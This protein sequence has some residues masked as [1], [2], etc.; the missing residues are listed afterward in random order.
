MEV[1][2]RVQ[3]VAAAAEAAGMVSSCVP[4]VGAL[5]ATLAAS[6]R[7]GGRI[8]ELG[9]GGG[10]G[11]A[12]LVHGLRG[13]TDV[14]ITSVEIDAGLHGLTASH[15]WPANV[16][17]VHGD[18]LEV[19][20]AGRYWQLVFADA[21]AGKWYGLDTTIDSLADEGVL[22]LDDMVPPDYLAEADRA[23]MAEIRSAVLGDDRL[24][25]VELTHGSG[26]VL[27]ARMPR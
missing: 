21:P 5:L 23:R 4:E 1:P 17:L 24:V 25:S 18:A 15:A 3:T 27:G 10:V 22:V 20:E 14:T 2:N 9:T 12:W 13:R 19:M 8:L 11:V 26:V 7:P 16:H 6:I